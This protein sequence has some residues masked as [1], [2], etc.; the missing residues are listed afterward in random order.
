VLRVGG[1]LAVSRALGDFKFKC[2]GRGG[3]MGRDGGRVWEFKHG[4]HTLALSKSR[5][6]RGKEQGWAGLGWA[7][8]SSKEKVEEWG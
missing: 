2:L 4:M 1:S 6:G 3:E 7:G 8:L 5:A